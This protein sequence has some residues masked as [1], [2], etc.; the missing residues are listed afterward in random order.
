[1]INIEH[2]KS[3]TQLLGEG[4]MDRFVDPTL[5]LQDHTVQSCPGTSFTKL[6]VECMR[7]EPQL[8][9]GGH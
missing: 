7:R 9:H 6:M 5:R 2:I 8:P 1:M 3:K 4:Y